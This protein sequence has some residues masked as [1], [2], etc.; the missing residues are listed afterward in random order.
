MAPGTLSGPLELARG[1]PSGVSPELAERAAADALDRLRS[2]SRGL[3]GALGSDVRRWN[4]TGYRALALVTPLL[5][6]ATVA[7]PNR[8]RTAVEGLVHP[9]HAFSRPELPPLVVTPGSVEILRGSEVEIG[10]QAQGRSE[11]IVG[12]QTRGDVARRV[13]LSLVGA[14]GAHLLRDVR[15]ATEYWVET[16]DGVS[17]ERFTLTPVDPLLVGDLSV[18]LTFPPHTGRMPEEYRGLVPPLEIPIGTRLDLEGRASRPL[19]RV[20]LHD[21]QSGDTIRPQVEEAAFRASWVPRRG[22]QYG[23]SFVGLDG[24]SAELSP[25]PLQIR[26]IGDDAPRLEMLLP[27]RDTILSASLRQPLVIDASDDYGVD[28]IEL[29]VFRVSALGERD[30]PAIQSL[31]LAGSKAAL[32]RPV[33]DFTRWQLL[34]G[35]TIRYFARAYDNAPDPHVTTTPEFVLRPPGIADLRREAQERLDAAAESV[36]DLAEQADET[37]E[38]MRELEREA[39]ARPE[40]ERRSPGDEAGRAEFGEQEEVRQAVEGQEELL[41]RVDSLEAELARLSEE[42]EELADPDLQRDLDELQELLNSL[43]PEALRERLEELAQTMEEL[44]RRKANEA[45]GD[46]AADQEELRDRLEEAL[47]RFRRA[48][49]EQEFRATTQEAEELAQQEEALAKALEEGDRPALRAE[50]QEDLESRAEDLQERLEDLQERL[51]QA[52]EPSA[53]EAVEEA[54]ERSERARAAMRD[55]MQQAQ[56][57]DTREASERA[58]DAA[59]EMQEMARELQEAQQQMAQQMMEVLQEALQQASSDALTLARRQSEILDEMRGAGQETLAR[60]RGDE[61]ALGQGVRSM[62]ENLAVVNRVTQTDGRELSTRIGEAM[63]AIE[64]TIGALEDQR[65]RS[66]SPSAAAES[67]IQALN[68]VARTAMQSAQQAQQMGQGQASDQVMEQLQ[69]LAQQQASLND[70]TGQVMPMQ[71]GEQAQAAEMQELSQGQQEI[72]DE[73]GEVANEPGA[74]GQSLGDLEAMVEEAEMLARLLAGGRLDSEVRDRQQRLFH[75][76]LDAGRSLEQDE[77]SEEREAER[78]GAFDRRTVLPLS[79]EDLAAFRFRLPAADEL[80]TLSPA[81][82]QMVVEYFERLNR[83]RP[84]RS[85]G[86]G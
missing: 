23:W 17:S 39:A 72:A 8:S 40:D 22:G 81:Q 80:R 2:A 20:E 85:G 35:D 63:E 10:V 64:R 51:E 54:G 38:E 71:L 58:R 55:A 25:E 57:G 78:P 68:E 79:D 37:A 31:E 6:L 74:E 15:A 73:L 82:R 42:M 11:A 5:I 16:P 53:R 66:P 46:V 60:L 34:S 83:D 48:A 75:R 44:D 36:E 69:E 47:E 43:A 3:E 24:E 50:Q 77:L 26:L 86:G 19:A 59:E 52:G 76:L 41:S 7:S 30:A 49:M 61:A 12:W 70:Q 27:G 13:T 84:R 33:L 4:R 28:R 65:G 56:Q 14:K 29:V 21:G 18:E 62:A 45:L 32:V 9:L 1:I 67:T